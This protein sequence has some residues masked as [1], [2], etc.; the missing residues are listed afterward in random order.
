MNPCEV[1]GNVLLRSATGAIRV[2]IVAPYIKVDA[3]ERVLG[4]ISTEASVTCVTKWTPHDLASGVS[5]IQCRD[6][7]IR[8][9]GSFNLHSS[10]HAKYYRF[11]DIVLVGS[12]NLS[13][14][15]MGWARF[16]N[17]E[18]LCAPAVDFRAA[19]FERQV[20]QNARQ[21]SD[22]EFLLWESILKTA[23]GDYE[24]AIAQ[25]FSIDDW[26]PY[27][28]DPH[29][30]EVAYHGSADQIA[31]FDEQRAVLRDIQAMRIPES[32]TI[33]ELRAWASACLLSSPFVT[34]VI[35]LD[36]DHEDES[37]AV[38]ADRYGLSMTEARRSRQTV[39]NWLIYLGL[40][41]SD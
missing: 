8:H 40:Y 24:R 33:E 30:F 36:R 19:A 9:G 39:M 10:L 16:P 3:L 25:P 22:R 7:V 23:A 20:L 35:T 37:S 38:L 29:H 28:R 11:D 18:I 17:V 5:D 1:H 13:S 34:D 4:V 14:A 2:L 32:M 15:A 41:G 12:A 6:A 27:T 26:R 31:S 21:I